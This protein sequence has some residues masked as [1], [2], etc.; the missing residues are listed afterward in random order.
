MTTMTYS[1]HFCETLLNNQTDA[2]KK[3]KHKQILTQL[4]RSGLQVRLAHSGEP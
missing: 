2:D 4:L 1:N 3:L